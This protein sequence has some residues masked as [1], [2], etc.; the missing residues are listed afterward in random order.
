MVLVVL[1]LVFFFTLVRAAGH[2]KRGEESCH[3][4]MSVRIEAYG[5]VDVKEHLDVSCEM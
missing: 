4:K 3:W 2:W 5:D 1:L